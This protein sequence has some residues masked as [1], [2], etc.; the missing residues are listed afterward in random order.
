MDS[1]KALRASR[2]MAHTTIG[3]EPFDTGYGGGFQVQVD[4]PEAMTCELVEDAGEFSRHAPPETERP[5][6]LAFVDGTMRVEARLTRTDAYGTVTGRAGSWG[7]GAVL[8]DDDLRFDRTTVGRT[9]IF[10]SGHRVELPPQPGGWSWEGDSI[11]GTELEAAR[12]RLRRRM[13]DTE[14]DIAEE[15]AAATTVHSASARAPLPRTM[16]MCSTTREECP[17]SQAVS[18]ARIPGVGR[19]AG[20]G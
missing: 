14:A 3:V 4:A 9:A 2:R 13:R 19:R 15:L 11:T 20:A 8:A 6:R 10:S 16:V 12:D 18:G 17:R 7:A 5:R 1:A